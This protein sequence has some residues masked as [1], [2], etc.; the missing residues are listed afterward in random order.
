MPGLSGAA[1]E[2]RDRL[3]ETLVKNKTSTSLMIKTIQ[4]FLGNLPD[5]IYRNTS[6]NLPFYLFGK[7]SL[8]SFSSTVNLILN[9]K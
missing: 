2:A 1:Y 5:A 8:D 3:E 7:E 9:Q 6:R 4:R